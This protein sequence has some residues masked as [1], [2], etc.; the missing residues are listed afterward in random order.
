MPGCYCWR[1]L[2]TPALESATATSFMQ[3][4][5]RSRGRPAY[6]NGGSVA[7]QNDALR[8]VAEATY[9]GH[10]HC[11]DVVFIDVRSASA[12]LA[13]ALTWLT[14]VDKTRALKRQAVSVARVGTDH[15]L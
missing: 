1:A 2:G 6:A 5:G 10:I 14:M 12:A 3:F 11:S 15:P 9:S 8:S 7:V 4:A 13:L